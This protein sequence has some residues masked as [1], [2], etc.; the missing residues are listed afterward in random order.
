MQSAST[1]ENTILH[2]GSHVAHNSWQQTLSKFASSFFLR[3]WAPI[4]FQSRA[5]TRPER[6][7]V[8]FSSIHTTNAKHANRTK[9]QRRRQQQQQR[10]R[11]GREK[12]I[13]EFI[14]DPSRF[15]SPGGDCFLRADGTAA[16]RHHDQR[17]PDGSARSEW[18]AHQEYQ[19]KRAV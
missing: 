17:L 9:T 18:G 15:L 8:H 11:R 12:P 4:Y 16:I 10:V 2:A 5:C 14:H 3:Q 7:K 1:L 13:I 6:R 19:N